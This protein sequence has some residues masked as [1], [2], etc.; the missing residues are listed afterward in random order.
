MEQNDK[1]LIVECLLFSASVQ[2]CANWDDEK[3]KRMIELAKTLGTNPS[4]DIEFWKDDMEYEEPW[5][6]QIPEIF[7]IKQIGIEKDRAYTPDEMTH[8]MRPMWTT[9]QAR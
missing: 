8:L 2:V 9:R 1:Q 5:A 6:S 3:Q 4:E 7:E